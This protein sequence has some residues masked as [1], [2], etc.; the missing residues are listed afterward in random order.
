MPVAGFVTTPPVNTPVFSASIPR[1]R[2]L[3]SVACAR[4]SSTAARCSGCGQSVNERMFGSKH[5]VGRAEDRVG[6]RGEHADRSASPRAPGSRSP[7][8]PTG[9]SSSAA[10][11]ASRRASRVPP[12]PRSS[13]SAYAVMRI[14]HC[15]IGRRSTV[16]PFSVHSATSSLAST[17]PSPSHQLTGI[18][19]T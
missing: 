15:R 5:H 4:Y 18:S 19:A 1:S 7:P 14:I 12:H 11:P 2:S 3:F 6:A 8:L 17:V 9:R 13:R 10:V 16:Y